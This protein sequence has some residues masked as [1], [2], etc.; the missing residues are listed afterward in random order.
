MFT[1]LKRRDKFSR[2]NLLYQ[3]NI[4]QQNIRINEQNAK[5]IVSSLQQISELMIWGDQN[6]ETF[7]DICTE[8]NILEKCLK[9]IKQRYNKHVTTQVLQ[10]LSIIIEN[11]SNMKSLYTLF[12]N[13]YINDLI[14][15]N[16]NFKDSDILCYYV[17]L[18]RQISSKLD[19]NVINFFFNS[20][21]N[22]FPLYVSA[23]R[24]FD[25]DC[26]TVRTKIM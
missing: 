13:N 17:I 23:L 19:E 12:S 3:C 25:N 6:D 14:I 21:T 5:L 1:V 16:F 8:M 18:L 11:M 20:K 26:Q 9:L 15:Y 10:S 24:F 7:F 2:E 4:L 22:D